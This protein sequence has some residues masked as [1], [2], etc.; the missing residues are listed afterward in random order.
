MSESRPKY[1]LDEYR[2]FIR[3]AAPYISLIAGRRIRPT[4][5]DTMT[6]EEITRLALQIDERVDNL[7]KNLPHHGG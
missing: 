1:S 6:D 3:E 2:K 4:E 7:K 5:A